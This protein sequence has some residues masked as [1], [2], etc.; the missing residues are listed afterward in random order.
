MQLKE[1]SASDVIKGKRTIPKG[2]FIVESHDTRGDYWHDRL[3]LVDKDGKRLIIKGSTW[4]IYEEAAPEPVK[5]WAVKYSFKN[6]LSSEKVFETNEDADTF[7]TE[8][9]TDDWKIEKSEVM[10]LA[11]KVDSNVLPF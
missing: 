5:R 4:E 10:V 8:L 1:I 7:I 6:A 2:P 9:D 11:Q 3:V